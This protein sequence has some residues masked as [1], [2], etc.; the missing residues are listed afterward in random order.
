M[1]RLLAIL[2]TALAVALSTAL[3]TGPAAAQEE[4]DA[5]V[6]VTVMSRNLYL[7]A[8]I[9]V[10][11]ELLPDLPAAAQFLWDQVAAT[12]FDARA[13][14][15]A[16]EAASA[17]P[18]VIG[19]QEATVWRCRGSLFGDT[20]P[21]FDFTASFLAATRAAGVPYVVAQAG[22]ERADN[23]GYA[24]GPLPGLTVTDPESFQPIFGTDSADCGFQIGDVLLVR[25]DLAD[26]VLAVG[27]SE[28][29]AR[30]SIVPTVLAIDRGYAWADIAIG[31]ATTRFVTTHLESLWEPDAVPVAAE[32]AR[33]L[34]ADLEPTTGPLVVMGDFNSD[35]RDP[36]PA[37]APNPG[38][39]PEASGACAAQ[40]AAAGPEDAD[41]TCSAYWTMRAG[42]YTSAGPADEDPANFTWGASALLAGPDPER[43]RVALGEG[44]DAGYT[45]RLDYVFVRNGARAVAASLVGSTWP[46]GDTWPCSDPEQVANTQ[47][48]GQVLAGAGLT[49][50]PPGTG[51]C[52][53]TD[54]V[55]VVATLAV[56][57]GG[58]QDE[59]VPPN[60]PFRLVWWHVALALLVLLVVL[61]VVL[62]RRRRRKRARRSA[63][64][65]A[66]RQ[67]EQHEGR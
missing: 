38:G 20:V 25:A 22:D 58:G 63:Q 12:N 55:G 26:D 62:V 42:G 45:D 4:A 61:V 11:L 48:A 56:P 6:E 18:D 50:P 9:T 1:R 33:Q 16:A 19:V 7:G 8:D 53:P 35:P 21:V 49:A 23:P 54:H 51:V 31:G 41:A 60:D 34:V 43:L 15:L 5:P 52:L 2:P 64:A 44:N 32:Q 29:S 24:I 36:R 37:G 13:P 14:L 47:A 30:T 65:Q 17:R 27:T 57:A 40:P 39:Q 10:A 3:T 46:Q 59:P 67:Q 28:Y 66:D